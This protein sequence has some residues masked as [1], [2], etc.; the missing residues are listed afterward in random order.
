MLAEQFPDVPDLPGV[1]PLNRIQDI[2][3]SQFVAPL[4]MDGPDVGS[5]TAKGPTWGITDPHGSTPIVP[6]SFKSFDLV[7]EY[8]ISDYPQESG[9]F[10]TY[11]KVQRPQEV[12]LAV[13]KGGTDD[14]RTNFLIECQGALQSLDLYTVTTPEAVY[15]SMNLKHYDYRKTATDGVTLLTVELWFEEVRVSA[16]AAFSN[17]QSPGAA[18]AVNDGAVQPTTPTA[19][20]MTYPNFQ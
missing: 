18:G 9:A 7:S 6:D 16:T 15:D 17:T 3:A 4:T 12:R 13:M 1:P 10:Q 8:A 20:E 19:A 2:P 14:D 5:Q 11:N